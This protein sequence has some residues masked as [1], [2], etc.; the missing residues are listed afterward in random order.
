MKGSECILYAFQNVPECL[1]A[2]GYIL[3]EEVLTY[4][5]FSSG[6]HMV[7]T[8]SVAVNSVYVYL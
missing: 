8:G 6:P 4:S 5:S 2:R 1:V 3:M 7:D